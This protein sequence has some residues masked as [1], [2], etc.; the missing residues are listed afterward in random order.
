MSFFLGK[1][2]IDKDTCF[3]CGDPA[4]TIEHIIPKWLQNRFNLWDQQ[5]TLPN[6]TPIFY[7]QLTIPACTKCNNEIFGRL[8]EKVRN[9]NSTDLDIWKWANK[10][11]Y[12]LSF[13]D[14]FLEWDRKYPGYKIGDVIKS[15]DPFELERHFLHSVA[16][17]FITYPEPFGSVFTFRFSSPQKFTFAHFPI[18]S[19]LCVSLGEVGYVVFIKDLQVLRSRSNSIR[20]LYMKQASKGKLEDMLFFYAHCI[21]NLMQLKIDFDLLMSKETITTS[22]TK[23][24]EVDR[25]SKELFRSLRSTLGFTWI[26]TD[27]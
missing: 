26:D 7:R 1:A 10:I 12:G 11:H 20:E 27:L 13:K 17:K 2:L 24:T 22:N 16:G 8:E 14:K 21:T 9:N 19:S 15:Y 23:I 18:T 3:I 4:T 6:G 5:I 25:P